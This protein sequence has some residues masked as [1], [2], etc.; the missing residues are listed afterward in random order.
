MY[1]RGTDC[2]GRHRHGLPRVPCGCATITAELPRRRAGSTSASPRSSEDSPNQLG[3][4]RGVHNS[5]PLLKDLRIWCIPSSCRSIHT[6]TK[7]RRSCILRQAQRHAHNRISRFP[8]LFEF[9]RRRGTTACT[10]RERNDIL[11]KRNIDVV[12]CPGSNTKLA[13]GVAPIP[14]TFRAAFRLRSAP[15]AQHNNCLDFFA[16]CPRYRPAEAPLR[17]EAVAC[18]GGAQHG[19]PQR[20]RTACGFPRMRLPRRRQ[21]GD[22]ILIDHASAEHAN[23]QT[24]LK[25]TTSTAHKAKRRAYDDRWQHPLRTRRVPYWRRPGAYLRRGKPHYPAH[26]VT[27]PQRRFGGVFL[28][29]EGNYIRRFHDRLEKNCPAVR[30]LGRKR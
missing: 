18:H 26:A 23:A 5:Y 9:S 7:R 6:S 2:P 16:R 11:K 27:H 29:S 15:T 3:F 4:P 22:L 1:L 17:A 14:N 10:E 20:A 8:G 21:T 25:R 19:L 28:F 12:S 13:S 24:T 30:R